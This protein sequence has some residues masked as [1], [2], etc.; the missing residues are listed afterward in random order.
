MTKSPRQH[1]IEYYIDEANIEDKINFINL[2]KFFRKFDGIYYNENIS[3]QEKS[4]LSSIID[5][6]NENEKIALENRLEVMKDMFDNYMKA[7][8][9]CDLNVKDD[10]KKNKVFTD[11]LKKFNKKYKI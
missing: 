11:L 2:M 10:L 8:R 3:K 1:P 9:Y 6:F 4:I 7:R 5:Y